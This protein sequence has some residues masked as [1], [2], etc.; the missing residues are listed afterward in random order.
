M[1]LSAGESD[2]NIVTEWR[3]VNSV[4]SGSRTNGANSDAFDEIESFQIGEMRQKP[5]STM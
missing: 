4:G 2:R 3:W 5:A 1:F